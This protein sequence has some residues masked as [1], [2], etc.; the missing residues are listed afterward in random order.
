MM[1]K[2]QIMQ[3]MYPLIKENFSFLMSTWH[4]L[5]KEQIGFIFITPVNVA[6]IIGLNV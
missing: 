6:I 2:I 5:S 1:E 4:P 3:P